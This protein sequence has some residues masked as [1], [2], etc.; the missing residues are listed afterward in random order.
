MYNLVSPL[1]RLGTEEQS[2]YKKKVSFPIFKLRNYTITICSVRINFNLLFS[3]KKLQ[4][5]FEKILSTIR[6]ESLAFFPL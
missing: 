5:N 2:P 4:K 1:L 6:S 3:F